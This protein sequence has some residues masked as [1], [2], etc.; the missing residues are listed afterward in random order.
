[1]DKF[2][3]LSQIELT[4]EKTK[5]VR[6]GNSI[7]IKHVGKKGK[8]SHREQCDSCACL[9]K[10][11]AGLGFVVLPCCSREDGWREMWGETTR[12]CKAYKQK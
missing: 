6:K 12:Q 1:M 8:V 10:Y 9:D 7:S 4:P 5:V 2:D 3:L 11:Q